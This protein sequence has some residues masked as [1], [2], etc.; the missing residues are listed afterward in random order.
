M[1]FF[2]SLS[3]APLCCEGFCKRQSEKLYDMI[4]H[5]YSV[6]YRSAS[7]QR[8]LAETSREL[9]VIRCWSEVP[10]P[11]TQALGNVEIL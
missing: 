3:Q 2:L 7:N 4:E 11:I 6:R 1:V 10:G 9:E 8:M 5:R